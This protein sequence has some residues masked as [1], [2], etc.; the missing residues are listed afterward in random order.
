MSRAVRW[1]SI[2]GF[3]RS[4]GTVLL[5]LCWFGTLIVTNYDSMFFLPGIVTALVVPVGPV[6]VTGLVGCLG[7]LGRTQ[8]APVMGAGL[9]F[10]AG[11]C[12][13]ILA[14][15]MGID[16]RT[17]M[18]A[19]SPMALALIVGSGTLPLLLAAG[20]EWNVET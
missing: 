15:G 10:L 17:S 4:G 5:T 16:P 1:A 19:P 9:L 6:V 20:L 14:F 12:N 13:S 11:L 7:A 2:L 8:D 3:L 18:S